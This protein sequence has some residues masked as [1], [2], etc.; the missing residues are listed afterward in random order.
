RMRDAIAPGLLVAAAVVSGCEDPNIGVPPP[1]DQMVFPTGLLLDPRTPEGEAARYLMVANG[2][3]DLRFNAGSVLVIDL[4]AFF[5]AWADEDLHAYPYCEPG[6]RCILDPGF[7]VD[8]EHPCRRLALLPQVV[9]C[10]EGPFVV[11]EAGVRI[12][13]LSTVMAASNLPGPGQETLPR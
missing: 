6:G 5:A 3:N 12:G 8:D 7:D 10:D 11:K 1:V 2:N 13:D 4:E 9:E